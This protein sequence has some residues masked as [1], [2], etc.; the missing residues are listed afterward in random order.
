MDIL[1]GSLE[2]IGASNYRG[3]N[4]CEELLKRDRHYHNLD[5]I[6]NMMSA[7]TLV[8]HKDV[9]VFEDNIPEIV[10][11]I[12]LHDI[13]YDPRANDNEERSAKQARKDLKGLNLNIPLVEEI[14]L[15]TKN[16]ARHPNP[17][18]E[19]FTDLDLF[20]LGSDRITYHQ[21]MINIRK[22]YDFVPTD[23]Y[24]EARIK[25][26]QRFKQDTIFKTPGFLQYEER[27]HSNL[28]YE[29]NILSPATVEPLIEDRT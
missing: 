18:I 27:A 9:V 6:R 19:F 28:L 7:L 20:I 26:L 2:F 15:A 1:V 25:I 22:E 24:N 14:I 4:W 3:Q 11:A 8:S 17:T 5:H 13:V 21:Y 10:A 16:H 12:W 23:R 29:M